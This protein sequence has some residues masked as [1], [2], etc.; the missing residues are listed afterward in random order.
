VPQFALFNKSHPV[1]FCHIFVL[2]KRG[3]L[4]HPNLH[5][6]TLVAPPSMRDDL[7]SYLLPLLLQLFHIL[8]VCLNR[9][10]KSSS[11]SFSIK[12]WNPYRINDTLCWASRPQTLDNHI[13]T[14]VSKGMPSSLTSPT[15]ITFVGHIVCD[16]GYRCRDVV[17]DCVPAGSSSS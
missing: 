3:V 16:L 9:V 17:S 13:F 1:F 12:S 15:L 8:N 5:K 4:V 2:T 10:L 14:V 11:F 6:L 7:H